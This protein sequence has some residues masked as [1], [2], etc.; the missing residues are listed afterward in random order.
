MR[1]Q[2]WC[3]LATHGDAPRSRSAH[4]A[5]A[6]NGKVYM[7]GG[8][9]GSVILNDLHSFDVATHEWRSIEVEGGPTPRAS[10]GVCAG[11]GPDEF[12]VAGGCTLVMTDI[13]SDVWCFN[14]RHHTWRKLFD[15]PVAMYGASTCW[16]HDTLLIFGGTTGLSYFNRLYAYN[17]LTGKVTEVACTGQGPSQ[18][19]KHESF[20]LGDH[21]YLYG[22]GAF[23][24]EEDCLHIYKLNLAT[25][26]WQQ[27]PAENP[28]MSMPRTAGA[29]CLDPL[30]TTVWIFGGF[31]ADVARLQA[32]HTFDPYTHMWDHVD[33]PHTPQSRAFHTMVFSEGALLVM[34]GAD[35]DKRYNDVWRFDIRS[36][37]PTL[38]AL[39]A[40]SLAATDQALPMIVPPELQRL[41]Q[42]MRHAP[43]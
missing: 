37:P 34:M 28:E 16:Y 35:G 10:P 15:T 29:S 8:C 20:I 4:G 26:H 24:P 32:F 42:D 30:T 39:A 12:T 14:A 31:S 22:G 36:T 41:V 43:T 7:F 40:R 38:Q 13:K 21:M 11:P 19:Y 27:V 2:D 33:V 18:R 17:V 1:H 6:I 9:S 23:V 5:T 25:R 3:K